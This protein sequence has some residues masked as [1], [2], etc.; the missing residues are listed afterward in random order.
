MPK[1]DFAVD[2]PVMNAAGSLGF[3]PDLHSPVDWSR[4][5]AFVTNPVSLQPRTAARGSRFSTFPGGFL[6]HSGY[7]NLGLTNTLRRYSKHWNASPLPVIVN[8]LASSV[9]EVMRMARQLEPVE[10]VT[11]LEISLPNNATP[12]LVQAFTRAALGELPVIVRLPVE[13]STELASGAINAGA[14]AISLA[15]PRG[16]F[17]DQKGAWVQGRM[18]GPSVYPF[19]LRVVQELSQ[20]GVPTIGAGGVTNLEQ[21]N[22]MLAVGATAVQLDS[23][24]WREAGYNIF[25]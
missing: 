12:E 4:L 9:E 11:G 23:I 16:A 22:A 21:V 10:G 19:S 1:H 8:L 6:L 17:R 13:R 5:G 18:Y 24:F 20:M 7:P 2:P 3:S 25:P 14:S 15:P